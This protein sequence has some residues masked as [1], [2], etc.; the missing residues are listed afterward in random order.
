MPP[1]AAII[2]IIAILAIFGIPVIRMLLQHQQKMTELMHS[3][4]GID[5]RLNA[6]S[7]DLAALKDLVHQQ[8]IAID[9]LS[10]LP[11]RPD[12]VEQRVSG[13]N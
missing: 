12:S 1:G 2:P 9:R 3:N 11:P 8:T 6:L 10:S 5:P 13:S 7:A 4:A